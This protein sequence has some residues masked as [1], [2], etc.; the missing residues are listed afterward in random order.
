MTMVALPFA[1]VAS[2]ALLGDD[3]VVGDQVRR[4]IAIV[5]GGRP[6]AVVRW[7]GPSLEVTARDVDAWKQG[8]IASAAESERPSVRAYL[9]EVPF[10]DVRPAYGR[11]LTDSQ[12]AIWV[13]EYALPG[14][15][16][17]RWHVFDG[18]GRWLAT[19][20]VPARF[21]VLA[22]GADRV[23]GV[24][25]DELDVERIEVRRLSRPSA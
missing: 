20:E 2:H 25:R 15:D 19:V 16:A 11:I 9:S 6:T 18:D 10:P 24:T 4:E 8:T 17:P 7:T 21:R 13:A 23:L 5:D 12:G 3:L 14:E 22:V 1:R